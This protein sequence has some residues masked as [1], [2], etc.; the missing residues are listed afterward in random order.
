MKNQ[1]LVAYILG[2]LGLE[3]DPIICNIASKKEEITLQDAQFLLMGYESRLEQYHASTTIDI[4]QATANLSAKTGN[5][6]R[7]GNQFQN[8]NRG[9]S[10]GGR[11][12]GRGGRYFNQRLVCQLC[13]KPGH[14]SGI[15]Y[16][17]F[18]QT[19]AGT[20]GSST[21]NIHNL[22]QI[23]LCKGILH[24]NSRWSILSIHLILISQLFPSEA[25]IPSLSQSQCLQPAVQTSPAPLCSSQLQ[26]SPAH[27]ISPISASRTVSSH[28]MV[29]RSQNGIFKP[30]S[31]NSAVFVSAIDVPKSV[32]AALSDPD[33]SAAMQSE[34]DALKRNKTWSLVPFSNSMNVVGCKWIFPFKY[35]SDGSVE[36]YK[37]RLVAKG[38]HQTPGLD[39]KETF[40]PVVKS[41]TIR[42]ILALVVSSN[43]DIQH[44]DINNAFLNGDLQEA[45]Y[46]SQP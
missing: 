7:G 46:M 40:S 18:D 3:F 38:F 10:R 21:N 32:T 2:G 27:T 8:N 43:W 4:S 22:S 14:F 11:R 34:F 33:W 28:P 6:A 41:S 24:S 20:L 30:K 35:K 36:R 5:F 9:R 37:A 29:T 13:G 12:G 26:H 1:D 19:F 31:L 42:I 25:S 15:C 23:I 39:F 16:H 45:V 17:R 44:I